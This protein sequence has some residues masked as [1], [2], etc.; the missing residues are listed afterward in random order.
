VLFLPDFNPNEQDAIIYHF[1]EKDGLPDRG[2]W[3]LC[4]EP[5]SN[6]AV[7]VDWVPAD[8]SIGTG[9]TDIRAEWESAPLPPTPQPLVQIQIGSP[10]PPAYVPQM[11]GPLIEPPFER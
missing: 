6:S 8:S 10:M 5:S 11:V 1:S 2:P 9:L 4:D 3:Q 7:D